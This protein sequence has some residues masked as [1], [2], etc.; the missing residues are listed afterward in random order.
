[1]GFK[2]MERDNQNFGKKEVLKLWK[3]K[4]REKKILVAIGD[5]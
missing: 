5:I 1:M 3:R 2:Q 4:I